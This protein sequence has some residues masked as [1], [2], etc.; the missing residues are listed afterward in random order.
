VGMLPHGWADCP[1]ATGVRVYSCLEQQKEVSSFLEREMSKTFISLLYDL[2][3]IGNHCCFDNIHIFL[4]SPKHGLHLV[5][6][7]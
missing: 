3:V 4:V 2:I 6:A 7:Y 1:V 5:P